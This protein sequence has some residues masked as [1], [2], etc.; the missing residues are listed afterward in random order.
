MSR[1][2]TIIFAPV[3][4]I[5]VRSATAES[6]DQ[7]RKPE[8]LIRRKKIEMHCISHTKGGSDIY[9]CHRSLVHLPYKL[10]DV[11]LPVTLITT[12]DVM[13]EFSLP[14]STSRVRKLEW[15]QEVTSLFEVRTDGED[16]VYEVFDGEDVVLTQSGFD[17][18]VRRERNTLFVDFAVAAFVDEFADGLE[19]GFAEGGVSWVGGTGGREGERRTRM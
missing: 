13:L 14:P 9:Y 11:F 4:S 5:P 16:F 3:W 17:G 2:G 15:P 19:V 7:K 10:V 6:I 8:S 1:L 12:L 18:H